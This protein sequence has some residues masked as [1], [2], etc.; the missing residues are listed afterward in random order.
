MDPQAERTGIISGL[1]A[2]SR[3]NLECVKEEDW[4]RCESLMPQ[5]R[6]L[7]RR[8]D[9][10]RKVPFLEKERESLL[11]ICRLDRQIVEEMESRKKITR[12]ELK[13]LGHFRTAVEGYRSKNPGQGRSHFLIKC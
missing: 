13:K 11:E 8:L 3:S 5:K 6:D 1:L 7:C 4:E 10:L 9:A 12:E 2:L